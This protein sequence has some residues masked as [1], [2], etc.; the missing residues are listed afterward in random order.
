MPGVTIGNGAIIGANAVVTR[1]VA[2][3]AIAVGVPARTIRQ[4]FSD[5]IASRLD[6]LAWWDWEH[7]RLHA[8]LADFRSLPVKAFIER[9]GG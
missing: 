3:F 7:E 1:D 9:H 8:A 6:A 4:R 5:D 2:N